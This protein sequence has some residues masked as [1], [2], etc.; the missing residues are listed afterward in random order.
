[1]GAELV[2]FLGRAVGVDGSPAQ[3]S[4]RYIAGLPKVNHRVYK[5]PL[6]KPHHQTS[7]YQALAISHNLQRTPR[8]RGASGLQPP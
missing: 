7:R 2:E 1:V 8:H 6:A 5:K 3:V 4:A